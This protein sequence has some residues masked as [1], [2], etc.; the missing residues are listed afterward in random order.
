MLE[1]QRL[2][3]SGLT[4]PAKNLFEILLSRIFRMRDR[5]ER[6]RTYVRCFGSDSNSYLQIG[7]ADSLG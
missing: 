2:A 3:L 6:L 7:R 1:V 4:P 5:W